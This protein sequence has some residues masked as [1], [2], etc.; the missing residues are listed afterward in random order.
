MVEASN[1]GNGFITEVPGSHEQADEENKEVAVLRPDDSDSNDEDET[2][3]DQA[4]QVDEAK[5]PTNYDDAYS[6]LP[7]K[8]KLPAVKVGS[9]RYL[10]SLILL[11]Y[12]S[13][14]TSLRV[15]CSPITMLNVKSSLISSTCSTSM[16]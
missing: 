12:V 5:P 10:S 6:T 16:L 15:W 1:S 11:S 3:E 7:M 14:K 9:N 4:F 13:R 8:I 2:E